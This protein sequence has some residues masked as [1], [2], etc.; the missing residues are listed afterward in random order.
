MRVHLS[1]IFSNSK[2][3]SPADLWL[4]ESVDV[5]LWM[6]RNFAWGGATINDTQIFHCREG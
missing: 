1:W 5:E 3:C 2:Y 4:V 6:Q